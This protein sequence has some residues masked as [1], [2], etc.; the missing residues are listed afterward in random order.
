MMTPQQTEKKTPD[1]NDLLARLCDHIVQ[2]EALN[3]YI[4]F[5]IG[6]LF[7]AFSIDASMSLRVL[8]TCVLLA[9]TALVV[10][11]TNP[12][13]AARD[14]FK[15]GTTFAGVGGAIGT[16]VGAL[17]DLH[18]FGLTAGAG[19]VGG[20]AI[21]GALG[22]ALGAKVERWTNEKP[23]VERGDAFNFLYKFHKKRRHLANPKLINDILDQLPTWDIQQDGRDWYEMAELKRIPK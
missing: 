12:N 8:L 13:G 3:I 1:K 2:I 10:R 23:F 4:I 16:A 22:A 9:G 20:L 17:V 19:T 5:V 14:R 11:V 7:I 15:W 18:S 21:G 6:A